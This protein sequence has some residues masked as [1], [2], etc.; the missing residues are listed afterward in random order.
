MMKKALAVLVALTVLSLGAVAYAQMWGGG[1]GY[2]M[3]Q[4]GNCGMMQQQG[5]GCGNCGMMQQGGPG[6]MGGGMM[7][8]GMMHGGPGISNSVDEAKVKK[9]LDET[10]T[11]R[12]EIHTK[13]FDLKEAYRAEDDK[14]IEALEKEMDTLQDKMKEKAKAAGLNKGRRGMG[15]YNN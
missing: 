11:L 6:M 8:P 7:G 5:G 1:E 2:G 10:A 3:G 9:F 15:R 4:G 14:K 12:K 13:M